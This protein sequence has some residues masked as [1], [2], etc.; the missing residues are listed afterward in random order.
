MNLLEIGV[1]VGAIIV[2]VTL[3]KKIDQ[4]D[5]CH[6]KSHSTH[7]KIVTKLTEGGNQQDDPLSKVDAQN[8]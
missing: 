7:Q 8:H 3:S 6:S 2:V 4:S 1:Y 5:Y